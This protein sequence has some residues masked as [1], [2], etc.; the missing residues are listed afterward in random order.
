[1]YGGFKII[2][3]VQKETGNKF[4]IIDFLVVKGGL[5]P[6]FG[7]DAFIKRDSNQ[8]ING[9]MTDISDGKIK[10]YRKNTDVFDGLNYFPD[11]WSIKLAKG[12]IPQASSARL[13]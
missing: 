9:L 13:Y 1:M 12:L 10:I 3:K 8:R 2:V 4:D 7:L 11:M 6:F 5:S